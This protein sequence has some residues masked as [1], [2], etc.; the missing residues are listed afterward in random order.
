LLIHLILEYD[1]IQLMGNFNRDNNYSSRGNFSNRGGNSGGAD[2]EMFKATCADCGNT[3]EIPFR[4]TNGRPVY[5]RDCF[6]KHSPEEGR[7]KDFGRSSG[8]F[9]SR[10]NSR[11]EDRQMFEAV[12]DNCGNDCKVPFQPSEG[13]Q[14]LC[15]KCFEEKGGD[16][17]KTTGIQNTAQ[18]DAINAKLDQILELLA[19]QS[20]AKNT[21]KEK[22]EAPVAEEIVEVSTIVEEEV[23]TEVEETPEVSEEIVEVKKPKA[24][25]KSSK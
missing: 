24:K 14:I 11:K 22:A 6:K 19:P 9:S 12:C 20:K 2:R 13:K 18:L 4:P 17:R 16:P 10:D 21:K 15:S 23:P 1:T 25:K 5:C 8:R 3:C 7:G